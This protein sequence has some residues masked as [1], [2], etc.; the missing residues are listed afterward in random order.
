MCSFRIWVQKHCVYFCSRVVMKSLKG[1]KTVV[2]TKN[3]SYIFILRV[4]KE[5]LEFNLIYQVV[6]QN[7]PYKTYYST[8]FLTFNKALIESHFSIT[9]ILEKID[10][11]MKALCSYN[12][13][14]WK[15]AYS[16]ELELSAILHFVKKCLLYKGTDSDNFEHL[17]K[18][19]Y[20][21]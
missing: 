3:L 7:L 6:E 12:G 2:W 21:S 1:P 10:F 13:S 9:L 20:E 5:K 4:Q 18:G 14:F 16:F 11:L 15:N 19:A 17:R 8:F